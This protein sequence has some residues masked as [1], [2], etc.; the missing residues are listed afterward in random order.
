MLSI[1]TPFMIVT[2][3]LTGLVFGFLLQKAHVTR[4]HTILN[5]FLFRD[6]TVLKVMLTAIVTGAVGI[7]GM[8]A[9][10]VDFPMHVKTAALA[11]NVVG[12]L[13]FGVGM[14]M[15]GFCP[16]TGMAALGD[17]AKDI[18]WGLLGMVVGGGLYAE[19]Y[20]MIS[21]NF[22]KWLGVTVE[23]GGETTTKVTFVD[24]TQ[25]SPWLFIVGLVVVAVGVFV[26]IEKVLEPKLRAK[27]SKPMQTA[28]SAA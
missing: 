15:L 22:L 21:G 26:L 18:K 1:T 4:Y 17:G 2:G 3:L 7:W 25:L 11:A 9:M 20:P 6:Y 24:V 23:V 13:I 12:G 27:Q 5:Q 14:A 28:G 19:L 10:G 16:G 8:R